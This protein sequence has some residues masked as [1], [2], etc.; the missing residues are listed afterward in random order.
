[1]GRLLNSTI[2]LLLIIKCEVNASVL[3][4]AHTL[5]LTVLASVK[6]LYSSRPPGGA[7]RV[8]CVTDGS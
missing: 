6:G 7:D 8:T 5:E 4:N 3:C 2:R 1:M